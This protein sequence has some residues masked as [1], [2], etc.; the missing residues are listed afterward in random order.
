M[1]KALL[2]GLAVTTLLCLSAP[3]CRADESAAEPT[4]AAAVEGVPSEHPAH[5]GASAHE[6][7][8]GEAEHN[9]E[10][11]AH[12]AFDAKT[13]ALQV[14]NFGVLLFILIWFGGRA[15]NKSLRSKHD[16]LKAEIDAATRQR[17]EAR[18]AFEAQEQRLGSLANE[19]ASLRAAMQAEAE[20]EKVALL[21]SA[22]DR[23]RKIQDDM[24]VQMDRQVRE[25]Q[26]ILRAEVA[27]A[28]VKLAE[29]LAKRSVSN[30]DER[31]LARE[32]VAGV[33]GP[34]G[35]GEVVR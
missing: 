13:F 4:H 31:R 26:A 15:V 11:G 12:A 17:D 30:D 14:L 27:T 23:V 20:R 16:Q 10:H 1:K 19:V 24:R 6:I 21:A 35:S 8:G 7:A 25:A 22:Q 34:D 3:L 33:D 18:R 28:S 32:F 5:A 29:D 9:A 2:A